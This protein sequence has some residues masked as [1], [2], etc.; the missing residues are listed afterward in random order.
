MNVNIC[1][2]VRS[3][4]VAVLAVASQAPSLHPQSVPAPQ[5]LGSVVAA[6]SYAFQNKATALELFGGRVLVNDPLAA[7]VLLLNSSLGQ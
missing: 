4:T 5:P 6:S 7:R 2:I 3:M 1:S